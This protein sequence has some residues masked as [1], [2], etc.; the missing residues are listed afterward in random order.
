MKNT[1][2]SLKSGF[3]VAKFWFE[4]ETCCSI[5]LF[6]YFCKKKKKNTR[7]AVVW[8]KLH[9]MSQES[10][11]GAAESSASESLTSISQGFVWAWGPSEAQLWKGHFQPHV[12]RGGIQFL[13]GC[14]VEGLIFMLTVVGRPHTVPCP[15]GLSRWQYIQQRQWGRASIA[16]AY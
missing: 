7:T 2:F 5:Y 15:M 13:V 1:C 10:E 3:P 6:T 4:K 12:V 14:Q 16:R 8:N 11:H 9:P